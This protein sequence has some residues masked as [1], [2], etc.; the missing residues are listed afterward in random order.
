MKECVIESFNNYY[1]ALYFVET[2]IDDL[3]IQF[4]DI[5]VEIDL[6]DGKWRVGI[7]AD[8]RQMELPIE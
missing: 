6:I 5:K 7:I 1:D 3:F 8:N 4:D 2:N